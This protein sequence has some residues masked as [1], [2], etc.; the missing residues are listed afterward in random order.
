[1]T[2]KSGKAP[3]FFDDA[4]NLLRGASIG[5]ARHMEDKAKAAKIIRSFAHAAVILE[6]ADKVDKQAAL[7]RVFNPEAAPDALIELISALPPEDGD[8]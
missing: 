7:D 8:E 6:V 5:V 1:M 3:G 2:K 4:V